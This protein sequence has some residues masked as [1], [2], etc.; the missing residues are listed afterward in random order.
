MLVPL[1]IMALGFGLLFAT[2]LV[3]RMRTALNERKARALRLYAV[4]PRA[5]EAAERLP[6][7]GA[8]ARMRRA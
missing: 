6:A 5:T 8:A 1:L 3:L 4:E 2:L 7:A